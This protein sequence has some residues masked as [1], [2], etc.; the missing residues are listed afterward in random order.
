MKHHRW[1]NLLFALVI[2]GCQSPRFVNH[3]QPD[4]EVNFDVFENAGCP[5]G[6]Y[7]FRRCEAD[8]PMADLG[9]DE[10]REP[11][12]LLEALDPAY[13]IAL[14]LVRPYLNTEEPG[15]ENAQMLADGEYFFNVGGIAP[16]Y[17]R[18]VIFR[19][20]QFALVKTE[21]EFR[22]MFA[23]V[24]GAQEALSYALATRN[25]S[26]YY[27]LEVD[28][29]YQYLVDE[30]EDTHVEKI[31]DGYR[32]HLFFYETFGCGPHFTYTVEIEVT[33]QGD[34]MEINKEP[35]FKDPLEDGLCVD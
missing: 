26:A 35:I 22:S 24:T 6:Q 27:D 4:L 29:Q 33:A 9:C 2:V 30:I 13:P 20:N 34:V 5:V 25:L 31:M 7:G 16:T 15:A 17:V 18:Y 21:N 8:G 11:S 32:V 23:P 1:L 19:D 3:P 28:P 12:N 14:C 10:L